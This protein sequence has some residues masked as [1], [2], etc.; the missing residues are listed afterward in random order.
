M[1]SN[2]DK[3]MQLRRSVVYCKK[4]LNNARTDIV[5]SEARTARR[6]TVFSDL[7]ESELLG[8]AAA[9]LSEAQETLFPV[10]D[11]EIAVLGQALSE[12]MSHLPKKERDAVLLYYFAGWKDK[13]IAGA[14][15]CSRST[16]QLRRTR[17]LSRL[18]DAL[19]EEVCMDDY[20]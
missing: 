3:E 4:A 2:H 19:E 1:I 15:G 12:A 5:R 16:V 7:R 9:P 17:A 18:R 13:R 20:L 11:G 10:L 14:L 8:I 6:E